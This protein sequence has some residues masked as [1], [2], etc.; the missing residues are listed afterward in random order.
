M[1]GLASTLCV[2]C[3]SYHAAP[4]DSDRLC[5]GTFYVTCV[6]VCEHAC[7]NVCVRVCVSSML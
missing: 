6:Y 4:C 3:A 1:S 5:I 2:M 7:V